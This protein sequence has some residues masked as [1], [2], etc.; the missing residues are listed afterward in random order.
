MSKKAVTKEILRHAL[1]ERDRHI[2]I[3]FNFSEFLKSLDKEKGNEA[4]ISMLVR[5][6]IETIQATRGSMI[7]FDLSQTSFRYSN[8][9]IY[10]EGYILPENFEVKFDLFYYILAIIALI[11]M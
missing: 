5:F 3:I 9:F 1:S 8:T 11:P 7:L 2:K 4:M 6:S 10:R